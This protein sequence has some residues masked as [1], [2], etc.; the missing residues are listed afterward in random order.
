MK[1]GLETISSHGYHD[2]V[3]SWTVHF[4]GLRDGVIL[5]RQKLVPVIVT[6][7]PVIL[8]IVPNKTRRLRVRL[9]RLQVKTKRIQESAYTDLH[10]PSP[11]ID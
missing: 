4:F 10:A 2:V 8:S 3:K 7:R 5:G 9:S 6:S 11:H 1:K